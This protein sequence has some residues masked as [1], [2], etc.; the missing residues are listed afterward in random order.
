MSLD[1]GDRT[2]GHL[3]STEQYGRITDSSDYIQVDKENLENDPYYNSTQASHCMIFARNKTKTFGVYNP[4][5]AVLVSS[6]N[7]VRLFALLLGI[8]FY[9]THSLYLYLVRKRLIMRYELPGSLS[10]LSQTAAQDLGNSYHAE[11]LQSHLEKTKTVGAFWFSL[12]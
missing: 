8:T 1:T 11:S 2:W 12:S 9:L 3:A 5:A 4:R 6:I 7:N 10:K